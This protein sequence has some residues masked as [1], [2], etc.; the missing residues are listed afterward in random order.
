MN[1]LNSP[2]LASCRCSLVLAILSLLITPVFGLQA[3]EENLEERFA[4]LSEPREWT[5]SEGRSIMATMTAL[6]GDNLTLVREVDQQEFTVPLERFSEA[7]RTFAREHAEVFAQMA[8]LRREQRGSQSEWPMWR[9]DSQ[10]G[11]TVG[12]A[13]LRNPEITSHNRVWVSEADIPPGRRGGDDDGRSQTGLEDMERIFTGGYASPVTGEGKIFHYFYRPTGTVYDRPRARSLGLSQEEL[14][15]QAQPLEGNLVSAHERWLVAAT[16]N[17]VAID[18]ETGETVWQTEL[19]DRGLN[20][21]FFGKGAGGPT[22]VY[23]DGMVMAFGTSAQVFGVDAQT[24]EV[25]WT[26]DVQPRHRRHM[27]YLEAALEGRSM[28]ARFNRDMLTALVAVDGMVIVN[29]QRWHRVDT[30]GGTTYHYDEFNTYVALDVHT[31]EVRWEVPGVGAGGSNPKLVELDGKTYILAVGLFHLTLL[32]PDTG[33]KIWQSDH[34]HHSPTCVFNIGVSNEYVIMAARAEGSRDRSLNGYKLSLNGLEELWSWG[35]I[36][37]YRSNILILGDVAYMHVN[38][39]LR[40]FEA[41]TGETLREVPVGNIRPAG[42]NPF[43]A[44]YGGWIF[45]RSRSAEHG[46]GIFVLRAEPEEMA[47]TQQFF[48]ADLAQP[49]FVLIFPA[50]ANNK[51]FFRTQESNRIEAYR[52]E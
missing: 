33:E 50:F 27:Q 16:D 25:R 18:Q 39:R 32:E 7:D 29:D 15:A 51:I 24:G 14:R 45:T 38:E 12:E 47:E 41:A 40:A 17:L 26:Y 4:E 3:G 9:W 49:Y 30:D 43:I 19:T 11:T 36:D 35:S 46:E 37:E 23:H 48:E 8:E 28:A 31:G 13:Q 6:E 2:F 42:G 20:Y 21:G 5:D 1:T 44:H 22:P 10:A 52:L 34:G